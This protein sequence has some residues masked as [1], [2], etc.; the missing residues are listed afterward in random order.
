MEHSIRI[1][2]FETLRPELADRRAEAHAQRRRSEQGRRHRRA[3]SLRQSSPAALPG[4]PSAQNHPA[5]PASA[6]AAAVRGGREGP[7][8]GLAAGL[9]AGIIV[10]Q[11]TDPGVPESAGRKRRCRP[12]AQTSRSDSCSFTRFCRSWRKLQTRMLR[13]Q[14]GRERLLRSGRNGELD[15]L[16]RRLTAY[17][18]HTWHTWHAPEPA[19]YAKYV[20]TMRRGSWRTVRDWMHLQ[21]PIE[22]RSRPEPV[23]TAKMSGIGENARTKPISRNRRA[24]WKH[25]IRFELRKFRRSFADLTRGVAQRWEDSTP[26]DVARGAAGG[27]L[28]SCAA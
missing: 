20:A 13:R 27:R 5:A 1:P 4:E 18:V 22:S 9:F 10:G 26:R 23:S 3:A 2:N 6:E 16:F 11:N 28:T 24:S 17:S 19:K 7:A 12:S 25:K 21:L 14:P 8:T 15:G